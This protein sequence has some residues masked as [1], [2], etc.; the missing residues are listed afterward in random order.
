MKTSPLTYGQLRAAMTVKMQSERRS[1][2]STDNLNAALRSFCRE[3]GLN[4]DDVVGSEMR[5][6]YYKALT[7]HVDGLERLDRSKAYIANRKSYLSAWHSLLVALDKQ[8]ATESQSTSPFQV[9]L[10]E[11]VGKAGSQ[12][13]LAR[14]THIALA[15]LK[16]WLGGGRPAAKALPSIRRTERLFGLTEGTLTELAFSG[17]CSKA[18]LQSPYVPIA[19]RERM[20]TLCK[21]KYILRDVTPELQARWQDF[22]GYKTAIRTGTKARSRAGKWRITD[23]RSRLD[24]DKDW[25]A[26][27]DGEYVPT[28]AIAW[29]KVA[30]FLGWLQLPQ[31]D[32]GMGMGAQQAQY[33]AWLVRDDLVERYLSWKI[34][35]SGN[36]IHSGIGEFSRFVRGLVHPETGYLTLTPELETSSV[37]KG[38]LTW[39]EQCESC[40]RGMKE[41][42]QHF[43]EQAKASRN[44]F[45]PI[46]TVLSLSNP[47]E[48][49]ADMTFRMQADRPLTN[50]T[51]EAVWARDLTLIRLLASNP[52]RIKN[53]QELTWRAD[54]TGQ[55]HQ[56]PDGSWHIAIERKFFKNHRGAAKDRDYDNPVDPAVWPVLQQYL[57]IHRPRLLA[58][59]STDYVFVSQE[60]QSAPEPWTR[61][62]RR[63]FAL[64]SKYLWGCP[65]VG[66]HA[67]R[68]I[69]ATAI[70]KASP[71]DWQTAA[72]VLHDRVETV[73]KHYAHLRS[74]DGTRRMH[75]LFEKTFAR[76]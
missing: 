18:P 4:D 44:P 42:Q 63:V 7:F 60:V 17:R 59:M 72:L 46:Q 3:R 32:G 70:L 52:L 40:F 14:E 62:N 65:G 29:K 2:H 48:A 34:R 35:R 9:A 39:R 51:Q 15:T 11:L 76:M 20:K 47:L 55:L 49:V 58:G 26:F 74:A 67:F 64:T 27:V 56:R 38:G 10:Q 43:E 36:T 50:G 6:S 23:S 45:E 66:P 68:H 12:R 69:V 22:V 8:L 71:N 73:Q 54:N 30:G 28:A 1:S 41:L 31:V 37:V 13:A 19:Y 53:L 24:P 21:K 5:A 61:M 33:L 16:R 57:S 25:Y 75:T